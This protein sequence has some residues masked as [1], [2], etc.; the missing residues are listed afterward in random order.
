LNSLCSYLCSGVWI[1]NSP[2]N[3][4]RQIF[5]AIHQTVKCMV[6]SVNFEDYTFNS[7]TSRCHELGKQCSSHHIKFT[8]IQVERDKPL[9]GPARIDLWNYSWHCSFST[10]SCKTIIIKT[11]VSTEFLARSV[12]IT[13]WSNKAQWV[14][15]DPVEWTERLSGNKES[16]A[17]GG[18]H[19]QGKIVACQGKLS[20]W[21]IT[22][23]LQL[24]A[25]RRHVSWP[26]PS[27]FRT[28]LWWR[29]SSYSFPNCSYKCFLLV[30][31]AL[32]TS[33]RWLAKRFP[34]DWSFVQVQLFLSLDIDGDLPGL[35]RSVWAGLRSGKNRR[36]PALE[37]YDRH[38]GPWFDTSVMESTRS[39]CIP[40]RQLVLWGQTWSK[41]LFDWRQWKQNQVG[42]GRCRLSVGDAWK[43][44]YTKWV[45]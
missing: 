19:L 42:C 20:E 39:G 25:H 21:C 15:P 11:N 37:T 43:V 36:S 10:I 8:Q 24:K 40:K 12:L 18:S 34:R 2:A 14:K 27:R 6:W 7:T 29:F 3:H 17:C 32:F 16:L 26:W 13:Y 9:T 38:L 33:R 1:K 31:L 23:C 35:L 41:I 28:G 4:T 5:Q 44:I 45:S 22:L 30:C